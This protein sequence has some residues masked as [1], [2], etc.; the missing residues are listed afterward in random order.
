MKRRFLI[1]TLVIFTFLML[2][3][4]AFAE[5]DSNI[6]YEDEHIVV[7]LGNPDSPESEVSEAALAIA[8]DM[9]YEYVW[10]DSSSSGNFGIYNSTP[11]YLGITVKVE[12]S[13][14][15]SCAYCSIYD[16]NNEP[17][18][19]ASSFYV[20]RNTGN[21]EGWKG[22]ILDSSVGTYKVQYLAYTDVGMRLMCWLY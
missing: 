11:G 1:S 3:N 17:C 16:P 10:L 21:G 4:V 12:S 15:S 22:T 6:I 18:T 5:T 9:E 2:S 7:M 14:A 19:G 8:R 20:D 13:S